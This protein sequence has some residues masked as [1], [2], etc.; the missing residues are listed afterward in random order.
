MDTV[1]RVEASALGEL[2]D[3]SC[4]LIGSISPPAGAAVGSSLP[5]V[6]GAARPLPSPPLMLLRAVVETRPGLAVMDRGTD[7]SMLTRSLCRVGA[8]ASGP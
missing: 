1:S 6:R 4:R 5:R 3:A 2:T 8:T 7:P